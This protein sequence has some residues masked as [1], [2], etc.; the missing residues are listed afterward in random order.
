MDH[1]AKD[2]AFYRKIHSKAY[3]EQE[4]LKPALAEYC[5]ETVDPHIAFRQLFNIRH[6]RNDE[7][8]SYV[9]RFLDLAERAYERKDCEDE[10]VTSHLKNFL[11]EG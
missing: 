9:D 2:R 11:L 6:G 7:I 1:S 10:I 3:I 4:V 5:E 8:Q